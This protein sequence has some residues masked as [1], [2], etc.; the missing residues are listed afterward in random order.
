MNVKLLLPFVI[1]DFVIT[2][3]ESSYRLFAVTLLLSQ[4]IC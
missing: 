3:C 4:G 1:A 2:T